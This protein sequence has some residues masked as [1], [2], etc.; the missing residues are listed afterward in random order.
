MN[1]N[2]FIIRTL[3]L[4]DIKTIM[5]WARNEGFAPGIGDVRIYKNTDS[6]GLWVGC[7]C[8]KLIGSIVGVKYNKSYGFLGLF[9]VQKEYR[10]RG[11]G[12]NLWKHV[13]DKLTDIECIGL[14][15]APDRITD[16]SYWGF[17]SSSKT[18][19][20][21]FIVNN[22]SVINQ[23]RLTTDISG[24]VLLQDSEIT[25]NVIQQYDA[26]KEPTPR[27]H[28]LSDWLFHTSGTVLALVN[29]EGNCLGFGRIRKCLL[30][31][32]IGWRIGPL[33]A[34]TPELASILIQSFLVRHPGIVLIDTP[35]LNPT[36]N[37]LISSLGFTSISHTVRM[38]KGSQ[39]HITMN[40]IYGLAC[41]ELG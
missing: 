40:E 3:K 23:L 27:P 16:Y 33:I 28:F 1:N 30:K 9:I 19:R 8:D 32:G 34:D 18:T 2:N 17:K 25:D 15:A 10:G 22:K 35:G 38:Y 13:L 41:L 5:N 26:N 31:K 24:L 29:S 11:Y 4:T 20:W 14:E 36:A 21:Q 6:Q 39:P 37:K 7:L 12:I